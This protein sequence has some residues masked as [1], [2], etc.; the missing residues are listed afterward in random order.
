MELYKKYRPQDFGEL[1]GVGDGLQGYIKHVECGKT[2][3]ATLLSGP[4]GCGKTTIARIMA[5][6]LNASAMDCVEVNAAESRGID[7]IRD[8]QRTCNLSPTGGDAR[9]WI[10]D[11]CHRLTGDAQSALLKTLEDSPKKAYFFLCTTD[12]HKLLKTIHSRCTQVKVK[13]LSSRDAKK[14]L[15]RVC[16][17]EKRKLGEEVVSV[18]V[19]RADGSARKLLVLLEQVLAHEDEEQQLQA[20]AEK[21]LEAKAFDLVKLF[22]GKPKWSQV[23]AIITS[24]KEQGE[25]PEGLRR[26]VLAAA[27]T[28][29]LKGNNVTK[30]VAIIN[31]FECN[32][33]DSGWAG[34]VSSCHQILG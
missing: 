16:K 3:H 13:A 23:A 15:V 8:I 20:L 5:K 26:M 32:Y 31:A 7:G 12:P 33:F 22:W 18:L 34:L 19:D 25:D 30:N 28:S 6:R 4:S 11:E 21:E 10:L 2:P 24:L 14:L 1:V 9:V 29:A 27:T 17:A